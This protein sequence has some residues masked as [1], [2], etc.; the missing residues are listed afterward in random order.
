MKQR[1]VYK[2][3]INEIGPAPAARRWRPA[4]TDVQL[5]MLHQRIKACS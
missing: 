4:A 5:G 1:D 3:G 2:G